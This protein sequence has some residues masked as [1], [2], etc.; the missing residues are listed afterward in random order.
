MLIIKE[1]GGSLYLFGWLL[2]KLIFRKR[3]KLEVDSGEKIKVKKRERKE[4]SKERSKGEEQTKN[5]DDMYI[6]QYFFQ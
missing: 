4:R 3:Y 1:L 5:T 6:R 2:Y